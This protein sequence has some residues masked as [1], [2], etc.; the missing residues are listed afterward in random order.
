L[1]RK[2]PLKSPEIFS[3]IFLFGKIKK[4]GWTS[5]SNSAIFYFDKK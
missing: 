1:L 2:K 4:S 3:G 5:A